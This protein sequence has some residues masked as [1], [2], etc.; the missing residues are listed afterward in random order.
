MKVLQLTEELFSYI[1]DIDGLNLD[2]WDDELVEHEH[3]CYTLAI[4]GTT[5]TSTLI[6]GKIY[7]DVPEELQVFKDFAAKRKEMLQTGKLKEFYEGEESLMNEWLESYS[8][9]GEI[10]FDWTG[11]EMTAVEH[12][13]VE[14]IS[15]ESEDLKELPT[16]WARETTSP[17]YISNMICA[18][19]YS[20]HT[21]INNMAEKIAAAYLEN[22]G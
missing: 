20:V 2:S 17:E 15:L 1:D 19:L 3:P 8:K 22:K 6:E 10:D 4:V 21:E 11:L 14:G 12:A 13:A 16:E 5:E 18:C 7:I 9:D